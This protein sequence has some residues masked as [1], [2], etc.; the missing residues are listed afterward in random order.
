MKNKEY[1]F[2]FD[3]ENVEAVETYVRANYK[4]D[5][6]FIAHIGYGDNIINALEVL[7]DE[8]NKDE[9]FLELV[10]ACDGKGE[11][12]EEAYEDE[13]YGEDEE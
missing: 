7:N 9:K 4:E 13:L 11:F 2:G 10:N 12:D 8:L 5:V 3:L 6:D 1:L